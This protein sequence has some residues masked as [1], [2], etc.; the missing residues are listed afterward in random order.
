MRL[1]DDQGN[2]V[3]TWEG[4]TPHG[5]SWEDA[6]WSLAISPDGKQVVA[7][8]ALGK[9]LRYEIETGRELPPLAQGNGLVLAVAFGPKGEL[10]TASGQLIQ[11]WGPSTGQPIRQINAGFDLQVNSLAFNHDGTR[12]RLRNWRRRM[13]DVTRRGGCL[14]NLNR[15][16][17]ILHSGSSRRRPR[18]RL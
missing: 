2:L 3:R 13:G 15:Q 7:G 9:V 4:P 17:P 1:W 10:A 16:E 18:R 8:Q 6:I 12:L 5:I 11:L 14:G